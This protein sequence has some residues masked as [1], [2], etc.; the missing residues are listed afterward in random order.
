[1]KRRAPARCWNR[2]KSR[3]RLLLR[4]K[5]RRFRFRFSLRSNLLRHRPRHSSRRN[6]RRRARLPRS[7]G[8]CYT[9]TSLC[10]Q[11]CVGTLNELRSWRNWQTHQLEGLAVAIP[12]WFES[13]R[14]H[15]PFLK[16]LQT[17]VFLMMPQLGLEFW[18]GDETGVTSRLV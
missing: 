18:I 3:G 5:R 10:Q 16:T 9:S 8:F 6:N 4:R 12:W 7:S 11:V 15:Q 14:P 1:M 2:R 17:L 13:T